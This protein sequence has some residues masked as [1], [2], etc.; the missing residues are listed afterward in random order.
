MLVLLLISLSAVYAQDVTIYFFYSDGCPHCTAE[1]PFLRSLEEKYNNVNIE[2]FETGNST[3][4][5]LF[6]KFAELYG[7]STQWVPATF[8]CD[9]Y[10]VGFESVDS[11]GIEIEEKITE[12]MSNGCQDLYLLNATKEDCSIGQK[13]TVNVPF[14]GKVNLSATG[15]PI[16]T[17]VLGFLDGFN[18]CAIWVLCFLLS[19]L[20]YANSR[21]KII[22]IGSIFVATSG[23]VY[24][25]FM[26]A[27]LNF[28]LMI[29]FVKALRMVIAW[30]AIIVGIVNMKDFF[31]LKKGISFTIP[32]KLKP[33]LFKKMRKLVKAEAFWAIIVGTIILAFTANSF[34]LICTF[35]FPA[36][37]TRA[38]TLH[39][40][41]TFNYYAYLA[42][43]NIVYVVPL[44]VIVGIFSYTMGARKLTEKHGKILKLI[45]GV[46]MLI[47]GLVLLLKP[48]ILVFG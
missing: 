37:Y 8:I 28:F 48:E 47:L 25:L 23:L 41:S 32:D 46:L 36:I 1:K 2:Y 43:Y 18:P 3:N 42:L 24:F 14:I 15:L 22:L 10:I 17:I 29:G 20:L 31:F 11:T 6:Q 27:W 9:D 19:L 35:G 13:N 5:I 30:V 26:A 7:S 44:A 45:S 4:V 16:L 40:L 34:E 39:N 38:L 12:C 21:K 33:R